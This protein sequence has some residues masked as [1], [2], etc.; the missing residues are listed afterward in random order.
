MQRI[1]GIVLVM[2]LIW[3]CSSDNGSGSGMSDD[4]DPGPGP[5]AE[6]FARG[7]MLA[8]WADNII[9]PAYTDFSERLS[10]LSAELEAFKAE[11]SE[12]NLV[13]LRNAWLEAYKAWQHID[14]FEIGPAEAVG[15]RLNLNSYPSDTTII[16][17]YASKGTYDLKLPSNRVAKGFPALDY[18]INGLG[19]SD[20]I[21]VAKL[22]SETAKTTYIAYMDA[23][24]KD[25]RELSD[26]VLSEWQQGY[27]DTF[28]NNEG[29]SA[30]ASVDRFVNDYIFYYEK[31]LRAGKMGI[32]LGVFSG[33]TLPGN[34][35]GYYD[36]DIS[37]VLFLESLNVSQDFFNGKHFASDAKGESLAAYLDALNAIKGG[38]DLKKIINDQF[39]TAREQV[40]ALGTFREEIE[41][42]DPPSNMLL[43]YDEVQR[44]V[45]L[46][47]VDMV[48]A[49][50]ISIAYVDSDGD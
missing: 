13:A 16:E 7:P 47:K 20:T 23:V 21:I 24:L 39:D 14:M 50:S 8:N 36:N 29:A 12:A 6:T 35:E 48:S 37:K 38:E 19:E 4:V 30:T 15:L 31:F 25:M 42:N 44:I 10:G 41:N 46:L 3:A 32:P 49:M 28:V 11:S 22:G 1:W 17:S 18:L 9:I 5:T 26:Q 27:R 45:P 43:A 40:T 34:L 2:T 33:N